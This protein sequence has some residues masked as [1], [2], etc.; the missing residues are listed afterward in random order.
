MSK[1]QDQPKDVIGL[2]FDKIAKGVDALFVLETTLPAD[3]LA[4]IDSAP[5]R[6]PRF[7][8][9]KIQDATNEVDSGMEMLRE[10]HEAR[11][12]ESNRVIAKFQKTMKGSD[13]FKAYARRVLAEPAP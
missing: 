2:A 9:M 5:S 1:K 11:M 13:E 12:A 4:L 3:K 6:L 7:I 10:H 8:Q